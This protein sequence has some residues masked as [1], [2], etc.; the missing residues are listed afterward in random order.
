MNFYHVLNRGVDKRRIVTDDRDRARFMHD[1]YA[2]NDKHASLHPHQPDRNA[3]KSKRELLV[4]I[5]AFALMPNHYHLL[6][7]ELSDGGISLFMQKLNMGYTKYFN[8]RHDRNGTLWQGK[9][10][11]ILIERDAH[12]MYIPFYIHLNPLDLVM[13]EWREGKVKNP[14]KALAHLRTY[15]WSSHMDYLGIKN[16][17]SITN[18]REILGGFEK[19]RAYEKEIISIISDPA[20]SSQSTLLE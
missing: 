1:L 3:E 20:I 8:E 12:F 19:A 2:F 6:M 17:P 13:P 15:R 16:F 9:Y 10:K 18:R 4:H 11:K 5:H 7:S 14:R